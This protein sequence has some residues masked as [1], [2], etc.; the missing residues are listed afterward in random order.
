MMA[1]VVA[2]G[3]S[4]WTSGVLPLFVPQGHISIVVDLAL[5]APVLLSMMLDHIDRHSDDPG[6]DAVQRGL[7]RNCR[8][9]G[10]S[11]GPIEPGRTLPLRSGDRR[12]G[13]GGGKCRCEWSWPTITRSCGRP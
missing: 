3:V 5:N 11:N 1:A 4:S 8:F 10:L 13:R 2:L 6:L 7:Q 9:V 12:D